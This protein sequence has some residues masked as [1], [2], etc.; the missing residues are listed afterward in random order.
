[1]AFLCF[2]LIRSGAYKSSNL[3]KF[4]SVVKIWVAVVDGMAYIS[5][6][7]IFKNQVEKPQTKIV[8]IGAVNIT[9][10]IQSIELILKTRSI[11]ESLIFVEYIILSI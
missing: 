8:V 2:K 6:Y 7:H 1:V 9:F 4:S 10:Y 5:S 11:Y 3:G